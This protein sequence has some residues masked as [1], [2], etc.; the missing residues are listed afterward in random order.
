LLGK[1]KK[2]Y[3]KEAKI[4]KNDKISAGIF[5]LR[6][7]EETV[8]KKIIPGQF[9]HIIV[10]SLYLRRPLSAYNVSEKHI[11]IIYKICGKGTKALSETASGKHIDI[12]GPL[13]NGFPETGEKRPLFIA[14]GMGV[15]PLNFLAARTDTPGIFIYGA[16]TNEE[17]VALSDAEELP[18]KLIIVTEEDQKK[19]VT[20]VA[21][22][23]IKSVNVVYAAGPKGMLSKVAEICRNISA[24]TY[25]S[26]EE[27]MGCGI[28]LCQSCAIKTLE[29]YKM[30]CSDGPVFNI[31]E[32]DWCAYGL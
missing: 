14:G 10:G 16:R 19:L 2:F 24:E 28:G 18:H 13:G 27:R 17:I 15:A 31:K 6:L 12:L 26:W 5:H 11:D 30:T 32:I 7:E 29:G 4:V 1:I 25:V 22:N 8:A 20:E 3:H 21:E 23:H 9:I